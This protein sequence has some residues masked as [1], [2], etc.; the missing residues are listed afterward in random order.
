MPIL[1]MFVKMILATPDGVRLVPSNH[2]SQGSSVDHLLA[3][4]PIEL[5]FGM[6]VANL[7]EVGGDLGRINNEGEF[8]FSRMRDASSIDISEAA[9][10]NRP[11]TCL[12][13]FVASSGNDRDTA[14]L[15]IAAYEMRYVSHTKINNKDG[16]LERIH[17]KFAPNNAVVR[18]GHT[19]MRAIAIIREMSR[20][21]A[22]KEAIAGVA[23]QIGHVV[24]NIRNVL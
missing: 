7:M 18:Y 11:V 3:S 16:R 14:V 9:G 13:E 5:K 8:N 19:N 2:S 20:Q 4:G 17:L 10:S 22:Q 21:Q 15:A 12:F 1:Q 6:T 23:R 24:S